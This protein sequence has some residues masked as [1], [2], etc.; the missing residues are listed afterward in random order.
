MLTKVRYVV[1]ANYLDRSSPYKWL[2]RSESDPVEK[3]VWCKVVEA[4]GF[5]FTKSTVEK[6]FGCRVVAICDEVKVSEV[7]P[8]ERV[9]EVDLQFDHGRFIDRDGGERIDRGEELILSDD[10][11]MTARV[12]RVEEIDSIEFR[13]MELDLADAMPQAIQGDKG[14]ASELRAPLPE[15]LRWSQEQDDQDRAEADDGRGIDLTKWE[16]LP[17]GG[18]IEKGEHYWSPSRRAI[19]ASKRIGQ[20]RYGTCDYYRPIET[21]K[22]EEPKAEE[23]KVDENGV[24]LTK[25]QRLPNDGGQKLPGD[26]FW[27]RN[28][29]KLCDVALSN[30]TALNHRNRIDAYY[31]PIETPK[32]EEAQV[33]TATS[34]TYSAKD[35]VDPLKL[36]VGADGKDGWGVDRT[37]WYPLTKHEKPIEGDHYI[38][39]DGQFYES[40]NWKYNWS[41]AIHCQ[42]YRPIAQE[43]AAAHA[44]TDVENT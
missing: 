23:A 41:Q 42:Y 43:P 40:T 11:S 15:N 22:A 25:W 13:S 37:K 20:T 8:A 28:R 9:V 16:K 3:A 19:V 21:P 14:I 29:Q 32:A 31:R 6:G 12:K 2:V 26:M 34:G 33:P 24:D 10:G 36:I 39:T 27:D 5:E 38:G 44:S 7:K 35:Y 30:N 17:S 18:T 4:K 1:S